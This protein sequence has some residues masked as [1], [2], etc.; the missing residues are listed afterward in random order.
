MIF[1]GI[2]ASALCLLTRALCFCPHPALKT[3]NLLSVLTPWHLQFISTFPVRKKK[4]RITVFSASPL[5]TS[6]LSLIKCTQLGLCFDYFAA[7]IL[8]TCFIQI[9]TLKREW[10]SRWA[11]AGDVWVVVGCIMSRFCLKRLRLSEFL[12]YFSHSLC[13]PV[14]TWLT[15]KVQHLKRFSYLAYCLRVHKRPLYIWL[16][17]PFFDNGLLSCVILLA[18]LTLK[19]SE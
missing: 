2:S 11:T 14:W 1:P 19:K 12:C 16:S 6:P 18:S 15:K 3:N 8:S 5:V 17:M 13:T 4:P 7:F 10:Q 9:R